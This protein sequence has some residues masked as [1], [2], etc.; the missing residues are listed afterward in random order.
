MIRYRDAIQR[1]HASAGPAEPEPIGEPIPAE[2]G[3]ATT[4]RET[5]DGYGVYVTQQVIAIADP[6]H[7]IDP[8]RHDVWWRDERWKVDGEIT[9]ARRHGQDH[10]QRIPLTR[11]TT[12]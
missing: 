4:S 10:H 6:K 9:Y 7:T 2:V 3:T 8:E 5:P 12:Q 11:V 1:I